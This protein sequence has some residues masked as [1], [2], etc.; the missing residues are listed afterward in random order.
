MLNFLHVEL[1]LLFLF[2]LHFSLLF[3][4]IFTNS[5]HEAPLGFWQKCKLV[6]IY[7]AL[8]LYILT[9]LRINWESHLLMITSHQF[10]LQSWDYHIFAL[11]YLHLIGD[12]LKDEKQ[13]YLFVPLSWIGRYPFVMPSDTFKW[14][15]NC[16]CQ[17]LNYSIYKTR[18]LISLYFAPAL[19]LLPFTQ[20]LSVVS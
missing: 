13:T 2:H 9:C 12:D 19:P 10:S 1:K 6:R 17:L 4:L 3:F 8:W 15:W 7:P 20:L 18:K 16:K 14:F 11:R 5:V